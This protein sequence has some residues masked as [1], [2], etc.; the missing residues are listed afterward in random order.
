MKFS[1]VAIAFSLF[2]GNA[3]ALHA[4]KLPTRVLSI[5]K[6][7]TNHISIKLIESKDSHGSYCALSHCWGPINKQPLRTTRQTLAARMTGI[8]FDQLPATFRDAVYLVLTLQIEYLWIDSLCIVQDDPEEWLRESENM[9]SIYKNATLVLAAAGSRD[10]TEGLFI[11]KRPHPEVFTLPYSPYSMVTGRA[12]SSQGEYNL[13]ILPQEPVAP[14]HGPLHQRAWAYQEWYFA[15][16]KVLFMPGGIS[17]AC[18]HREYNEQWNY[19]KPQVLSSSWL[20]LLSEYTGKVL[21]YPSDRLVAIRGIATETTGA[22]NL[23]RHMFTDEKTASAEKDA[24]EGMPALEVID[25]MFKFGVWKAQLLEQLLW[26]PIEMSNEDEYLPELPTWSWAA[27]GGGK[28]W[29]LSIHNSIPMRSESQNDIATL[30][31]LDS[32][33]VKA[34]GQL[35]SVET[36]PLQVCCVAH[37]SEEVKHASIAPSLQRSENIELAF[38]MLNS[39]EPEKKMN[40]FLMLD[41]RGPK[42]GKIFGIAR[43]D[44]NIPTQNVHFLVMASVRRPIFDIW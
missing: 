14:S 3:Y 19:S 25:S 31:L 27:S 10:S 23:F 34:K 40:D 30:E 43:L 2:A 1:I 32:G 12:A 9:G 44:R 41:P 26:L 8:A 37:L 11:T 39:G 22:S 35:L 17:W 15:N 42:D 24:S 16:R 28:R 4:S 36:A 18:S 29:P 33:L 7:A 6:D 5:T 20:A 38:S 21:T 13:A